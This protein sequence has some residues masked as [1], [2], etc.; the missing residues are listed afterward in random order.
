MTS[1]GYTPPPRVTP[2]PPS[3]P[4]SSPLDLTWCPGTPDHLHRTYGGD[5]CAPCGA[6]EV[7]W[8]AQPLPSPPR[9]PSPAPSPGTDHQ[10]PQAF[11]DGE[12]LAYRR[13]LALLPEQAAYLATRGRD[14]GR[15][16]AFALSE[17]RSAVIAL[18]QDAGVDL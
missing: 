7:T 4:V 18:A 11:R 10:D 14:E 5:R 17:M 8:T 15:G 1:P 6:W 2:Q 12:A 9:A 13:V 3:T 16:A